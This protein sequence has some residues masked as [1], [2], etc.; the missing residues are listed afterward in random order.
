MVSTINNMWGFVMP[1]PY[2]T[3]GPVRFLSPYDFS[4]KTEW[5]ARRNFT[6][7]LFSWSH[8]A[9]GPVRLDTTVHLWF[10][11]ISGRTQGSVRCPYGHRATPHRSLHYFSYP[12]G[13]VRGPCGTRKGAVRHTYGHVREL[14]QPEFAKIPYGRLMWPYGD[15]RAPYGSHTGCSRTVYDLLPR[16]GP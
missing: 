6:P 10:D 15:R 12:T 2:P 16:T 4:H 1:Q 13:H 14:P 3:T 5:N 11:R 7:V 9:T 8:Q